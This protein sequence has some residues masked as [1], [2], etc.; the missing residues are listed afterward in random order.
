MITI[1]NGN[2][3]KLLLIKEVNMV[4]FKKALDANYGNNYLAIGLPQKSS[5]KER[6]EIIQDIKESITAYIL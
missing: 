3:D 1:Q 5:A 2:P 4:N 6:K